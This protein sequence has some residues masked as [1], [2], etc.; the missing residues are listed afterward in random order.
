VFDDLAV[1][2]NYNSLSQN[3]QECKSVDVHRAHNPKVV[4]S[5]PNRAIFMNYS[6]AGNS[7]Q[8]GDLLLQ[9][10]EMAVPTG[11]IATRNYLGAK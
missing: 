1:A 2:G 9:G 3:L 8:S 6:L 7:K 10:H 4:H 5:S 11:F